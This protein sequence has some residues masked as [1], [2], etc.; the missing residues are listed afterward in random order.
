MA[1]SDAP[2]G[3]RPVGN[4]S[5]APW[6]GKLTKV[7]IPSTDSAAAV[8]VGGLVKLT[9]AGDSDG[10]PVVTG[11][12]SSANTVLGVVVGFLPSSDTST[13]YRVNSTSRYAMVVTDPNTIFE[14]QEDSAGGALAAGAV[15]ATANLTGLTSGSTVTGLSAIEIDS[16]TLSET[17]DTDDDV[18]ILG[19]AQRPD[20]AIGTNAK[21]LVRLNNHAYVDA[22]VGV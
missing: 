10:I 7:Y 1:N 22:A 14:V 19:L 9:G 13:T 6:N 18:L 8:Y 2:F 20:N 17:S 21:W 4:L 11:N 12:V 16:D 5:G 3:L 15:G